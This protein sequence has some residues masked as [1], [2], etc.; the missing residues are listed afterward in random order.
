MNKSRVKL[1]VFFTLMAVM[2]TMVNVP[3]AEARLILYTPDQAVAKANLVLVGTVGSVQVGTLRNSC[4]IKIEK[5]LKGKLTQKTIR[6]TARS[7]ALSTKL[8]NVFPPRGARI[9]AAI[10]KEGKYYRLVSDR[11]A[12]ALIEK[13]HVTKLYRGS[14][15]VINK[16]TWQPASYVKYYDIYYHRGTTTVVAQPVTEKGEKVS[17]FLSETQ[18]GQTITIKPGET[19][20]VQLVSNPS[21]GFTWAYVEKPDAAIVSVA[22]SYYD[23][24]SSTVPLVGAAGKQ[25]WDIK[26]LKEGAVT[27]DLMYA[28]P[29]ESVQP[30]QTFKLYIVVASAS[31]SN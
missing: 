10:N 13:G 12:I 21:T 19:I 11:N 24:N 3:G 23:P 26:G 17:R 27:L 28:R 31:S 16:K 8:K 15:F 1:V 2:L 14:A 22:E 18:N 30:A 4:D 7:S 6:V 9:F 29:W 5:V 25:T 20:Q